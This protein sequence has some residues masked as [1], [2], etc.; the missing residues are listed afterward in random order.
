[1]KVIIPLAGLGKRMRPHTWSKP[2]PLLNVAGKPILG[3]VL[4]KFKPLGVEEV[5]LIVGWL[6]DQINEY[7]QDN[8]AFRTHYVVQHE[9]KGQ[10]HAL[11]LAK[12]YLSGPCIIVFVDTLF[13]VDLSGLE[14]RPVDGVIYVQTVEDPRRFGVVVEEQGRI[15][16]L[17]EKP[18]GFEHRKAV[19]GLYY[20]KDGAA[21]ADAIEYVLTHDIQTKGEYYLANALQVMIDR[22]ARFVSEPVSAWED[23]GEPETLLH[24]NRY[25]LEHGCAQEATVQN[26]VLVPPVYIAPTAVVENAIIGP[27]VTVGDKVSISDSIVRDAIIDAGS[28]IENIALEHSLVGRNVTLK[29]SFNRVNIGDNDLIDL[30]GENNLPKEANHDHRSTQRDQGS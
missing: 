16:R 22:G 11:Y 30:T 24:T 29:G 17:I 7:V 23:C 1:M 6:G 12:E 15:V 10:A 13:E 5:I 4:D 8:Y 18:D 21:L 28:T 2:K 27:Y 19:I 3:H 25:L 20:I 26:A 9:L 14:Q